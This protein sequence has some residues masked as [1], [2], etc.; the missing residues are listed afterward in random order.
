MENLYKVP[1]KDQAIER[2]EWFI[3]EHDLK[4]SSKIPSERNLSDMFNLSRTTIRS[5]INRLIIEGKLYTMNGSGTYVA[6]PKLKINLHGLRS[7]TETINETKNELKTRVISYRIFEANK[8]ISKKFKTVLG[9]KFFELTRCRYINGAPVFYE[10]STTDYE[11]FP[12]IE[13]HDFSTESLFEVLEKEYG[14]RI[15]KGHESLGITFATDIE[16]KYL[17]IE[18]KT[19]VYITNGVNM[20]ENDQVTEYSKIIVRADKVCYTVQFMTNR[21]V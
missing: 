6:D 19:P 15:F 14:V 8:S 11:R 21:E 9:H 17:K 5:A 2:I 3:K 4:P 10:I 12:N 16:A 20:D 7:T 18:E 1:P 13:S